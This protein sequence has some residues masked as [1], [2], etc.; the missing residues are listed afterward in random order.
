MPITIGA[1]AGTAIA[2]PLAARGGRGL[3][4]LGGLLQ[5]LA[6]AWYALVV[7]DRGAALSGWDLAW[8]LASAAS[9]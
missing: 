7:D 5:A 4:L 9:A 1:F 6:F 2:A 8:P 3:V